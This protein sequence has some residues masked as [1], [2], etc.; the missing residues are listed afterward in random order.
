[1][2]TTNVLFDLNSYPSDWA[3]GSLRF[4]KSSIYFDTSSE[5]ESTIFS[6]CCSTV[7][8]QKKKK[9]KKEILFLLVKNECCCVYGILPHV[10]LVH[11]M[12]N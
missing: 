2:I 10:N 3:G 1:M 11:K 6:Q 8:W 5:K 12:R 4:V 9:E 7:V